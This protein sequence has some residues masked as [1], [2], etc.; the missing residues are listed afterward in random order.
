MYKI[1]I[2]FIIIFLFLINFAYS[3]I[4]K[5]VEIKGN[6]R[7]SEGTILVL[8]DIKIGKDFLKDS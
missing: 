1:L 6:Q 4:I 3:E 2:K 8:S 5:K 7:I